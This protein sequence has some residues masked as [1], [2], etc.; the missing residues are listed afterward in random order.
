MR[1]NASL[2]VLYAGAQESFAGLD[3]INVLLPR[4]LAGQGFGDYMGSYQRR[5]SNEQL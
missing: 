3:P 4:E 5:L 2:N 1:F